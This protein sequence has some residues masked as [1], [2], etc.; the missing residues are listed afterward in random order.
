[1]FGFFFFQAEDGIRDYKVTGVQ[2]CALPIYS[3]FFKK[4]APYARHLRTFG[5]MGV[6]AITS[7]KQGRTKLDSR[8]QL[9]M[10]LGYGEVHAGDV[11]RFLNMRTKRIIHS[12]DVQWMNK[13]WS[14]YYQVPQTHTERGYVDPFYELVLPGSQQSGENVEQDAQEEAEAEQHNEEEDFPQDEEEV[15]AE[16]EG[17]PIA[18]R[19]RSQ[20]QPIA[21]RTRSRVDQEDLTAFADVH[22][23][24]NMNEWLQEVAFVTGTMSDPE[25]PQTFQQAWWCEGPDQREKWREADRIE[26]RKM[27]QMGVWSKVPRGG[28]TAER[29][30]VGCKWVFKLKR[31]GVYRARLVAKGFSQIPGVDFTENFSPVVNDVTFRLVLTRMIIE[32][33]HA[34]VV[35]IDNAFLNGDLDHEIYMNIP[36]GY[37]E[38]IGETDKGDALRLY[39]SIYGLVQAAR[40]F[41]KK[42]TDKLKESGFQSSEV[43]PCLMHREDEERICILIMY[44]NDLLII[45]R[46]AA[47]DNAV[48]NLQEHFQVKKPT[49][50]DDYLGVQIIRSEDQTKA[51]LGQPTILASLEKHFGEQVAKLRTTKTPGTPG[52]VGMKMVE[53]EDKSQRRSKQ[54]IIQEWE[55]C[56]IS[57]SIPVQT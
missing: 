55:H 50:L 33:L 28:Q 43:D 6:T 35:D 40:Q 22:R 26:F 24:T 44:I 46:E 56:C 5:E 53:E 23:G 51:W 15:H 25:E 29:R 47:I 30:L 48:S 42:I 9:A 7:N 13:M 52:F 20:V 10:L 54:S 14:Q 16:P 49:T 1:M 36:D 12:R 4:D 31:N 8:G 2:T 27:E 39:K 3:R 37:K 18:S 17:Q 57:Q 11:Y 45:G 32:G 38:C 41:W 19:T 21:E 34:K